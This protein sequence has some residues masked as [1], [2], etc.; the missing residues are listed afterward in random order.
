ME[1]VM[2]SKL[3]PE[4]KRVVD[5]IKSLNENPT[6][7]AV[8]LGLRPSTIQNIWNGRNLPGLTTIQIMKKAYPFELDLDWLIMGPASENEKGSNAEEPEYIRKYREINNPAKLKEI[9]LA[10]E[11]KIRLISQTVDSQRETIAT[12]R[13]LIE[14]MR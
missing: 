5:F 9:I 4:N 12:Q 3:S 10:L 8:K 11:E 1:N 14:K 7:F 2:E 13:E 6:S